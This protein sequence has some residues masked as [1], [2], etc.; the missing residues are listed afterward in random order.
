MVGPSAKNLATA[1]YEKAV[2]TLETVAFPYLGKRPIDKIT[3]AEVLK[4]T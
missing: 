2:C 4:A 3:A 1:T